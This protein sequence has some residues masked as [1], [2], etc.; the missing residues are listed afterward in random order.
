[1]PTEPNQPAHNSN[2]E[3]QQIE[4]TIDLEKLARKIYEMMKDEARIE[5]E[6]LGRRYTR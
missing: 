1:M 6:R 2:E 5:R 4:D 3:P